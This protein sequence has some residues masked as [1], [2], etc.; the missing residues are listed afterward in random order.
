MTLVKVCGLREEAHVRAARD[1][2]AVGFVVES[3][4]S[5]RDLPLAE[6]ARLVRAAGPLQTTVAVTASRDADALL[7]IVDQVRPHALQAPAD[8]AFAPVRK[9]H[10]TLRILAAACPGDPAP[11]EADL[12]VL[13]AATGDGYGGT[14]R[15]LDPALARSVISSSPIP[16]LLAGGLA[17]ENVAQAIRDARPHG[18]DASSGL[19]TEGR[20]DPRKIAEFVRQARSALP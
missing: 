3:P 1:A 6:A 4:R 7:R 13:D 18:V 10:P 8:A 2:D 14:G 20:K 12:L 16:V 9:L 5:P 19:E 11:P 17:P 15:R